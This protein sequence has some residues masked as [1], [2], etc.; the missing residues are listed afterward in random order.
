VR[1][2]TPGDPAPVE[3]HASHPSQESLLLAPHGS[4]VALVV[5]ANQVQESMDDQQGRLLAQ[6][7]SGPA[8]LARSLHHADGDLSKVRSARLQ[9]PFGREGE[10]IRAPVFATVEAIETADFPVR[11]KKQRHARSPAPGLEKEA[12]EHAA[13]SRRKTATRARSGDDLYR[14]EPLRSVGRSSWV[15]LPRKGRSDTLSKSNPG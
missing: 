5:I 8:S 12:P 3:P 2:T 13:A 6:A 15:R 14:I 9:I 10:H 7:P 4:S 11:R 1:R